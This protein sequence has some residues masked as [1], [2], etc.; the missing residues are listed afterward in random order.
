M[1]VLAEYCALFLHHISY[2]SLIWSR[3]SEEKE[4]ES[5]DSRS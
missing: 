3:D 4:E 5:F 2:L 1:C